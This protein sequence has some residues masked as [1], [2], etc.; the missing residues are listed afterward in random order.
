MKIHTGG[1]LGPIFTINLFCFDSQLQVN[2]MRQF[3]GV[4]HSLAAD[5]K[6]HARRDQQKGPWGTCHGEFNWWD[7]TMNICWN[8]KWMGNPLVLNNKL[9]IWN[10]E[11]TYRNSKKN[12][13]L[14]DISP[15]FS[16]IFS[17]T[18]KHHRPFF[19]F[20]RLVGMYEL[21]ELNREK[22]DHHVVES[23]EHFF[24]FFSNTAFFF[25]KK[26]HVEVGLTHTQRNPSRS[27][28]PL[29]IDFSKK[30]LQRFGD[31]ALRFVLMF[32]NCLKVSFFCFS[33]IFG[34]TYLF[35]LFSVWCPYFFRWNTIVF[36]CFLFLLVGVSDVSVCCRKVHRI[37]VHY[38]QLIMK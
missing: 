17:T 19:L 38:H 18:F 4:Y 16:W 9:H 7:L 3:C 21:D 13:P 33:G 29:A 1:Y 27:W 6:G 11:D 31:V 20:L 10:L 24:V 5:I 25:R 26:K 14:V 35:P 32:P 12:I 30:K 37:H 34:G 15:L 8:R 22:M 28:Y 2:C 36:W 23:F